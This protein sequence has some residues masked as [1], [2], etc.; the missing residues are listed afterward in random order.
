MNQQTSIELNPSK[1]DAVIGTEMFHSI[2]TKS[3][4][5]LDVTHIIPQNF[6]IIILR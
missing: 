4:T 1:N 6:S 5:F 2:P 3:I